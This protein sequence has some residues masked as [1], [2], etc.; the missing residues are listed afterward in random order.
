MI[1]DLYSRRVVGWSM[2]KRMTTS[3]VQNALNSAI[4]GRQPDMGVLFH[5]D[6]GVQYA[7]ENYQK[8]LADQG[9]KYSKSRKGNCCD[10]VVAE[11]F[12]NSLKQEWLHHRK[13]KTR[14]D[15]RQR[16][17]EYIEGFYNSHRL[18]STF[19]RG[20]GINS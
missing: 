7:P 16:I 5:S 10:N 3:L 8:N 2:S 4:E 9:I 15:A 1:L 14:S 13:F 20:G 17:V 19:F 6:R 12:F 11:S 18:H